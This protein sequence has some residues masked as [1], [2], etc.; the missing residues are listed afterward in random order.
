MSRMWKGKVRLEGRKERDTLDTK[1]ARSRGLGN[2]KGTNHPELKRKSS[3][4]SMAMCNSCDMEQNSKDRA[5]HHST[6]YKTGI[7]GHTWRVIQ[8]VTAK[9]NNIE[10][11]VSTLCRRDS[12]FS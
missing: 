1:E 11:A 9:H 10:H 12:M 4:A 8:N 5:K 7:Q 2:F 3:L 6:L